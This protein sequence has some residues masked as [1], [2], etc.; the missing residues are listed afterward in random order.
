MMKI[1]EIIVRNRKM[2]LR[3]VLSCNRTPRVRIWYVE[4]RTNLRL[5]NVL[6]VGFVFSDTELHHLLLYSQL[7]SI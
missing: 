6:G 2:I 4:D 5:V 3:S 1:H 7:V